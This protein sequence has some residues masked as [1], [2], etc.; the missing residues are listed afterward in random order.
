M[1]WY[2]VRSTSSSGYDSWNFIFLNPPK[3]KDKNKEKIYEEL[4]MHIDAPTWSEHYRGIQF[5]QIKESDI[6]GEYFEKRLKEKLKEIEDINKYG[7]IQVSMLKL[8]VQAAKKREYFIKCKYCKGKGKVKIPNH[9][10]G[11]QGSKK[12][13]ECFPCKGSGKTKD[14][15]IF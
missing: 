15:S 8:Q 13:T 14:Y 3:S 7:P 1:P 11:Y 10:L 5:K 6:P 2:K 4:E 12:Y 9:G